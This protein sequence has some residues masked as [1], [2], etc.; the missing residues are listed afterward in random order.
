MRRAE[1]EARMVYGIELD[2]VAFTAGT[3]PD[4]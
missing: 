2:V 1:Q 3:G 4:T